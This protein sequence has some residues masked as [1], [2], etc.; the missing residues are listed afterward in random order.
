MKTSQTSPSKYRGKPL[1]V[2]RTI[3]GGERC[4][5]IPK[6]PLPE[7]DSYV[8]CRAG[9]KPPRPGDMATGTWSEKVPVQALVENFSPMPRIAPPPEGSVSAGSERA[10]GSGGAGAVCDF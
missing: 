3:D 2:F 7:P 10:P 8:S 4:Q 6:A 5:P 9:P 1:S